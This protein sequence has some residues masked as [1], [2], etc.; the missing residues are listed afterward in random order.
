[1]VVDRDQ[2][3]LDRPVQDTEVNWEALW[4]AYTKHVAL[5]NRA[6]RLAELIAS[7]DANSDLAA[8]QLMHAAINLRVAATAA[9][10]GKFTWPPAPSEDELNN[11][12]WVERCVTRARAASEA[13]AENRRRNARLT[14]QLRAVGIGTTGKGVPVWQQKSKLSLDELADQFVATVAEHESVHGKFER[15]WLDPNNSH[16]IDGGMTNK[17]VI[18]L[19]SMIAGPAERPFEECFNIAMEYMR[20]RRNDAEQTGE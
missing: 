17:Q 12:A 3:T 4:Q 9:G 20:Q 11:S 5:E 15:E 6:G 16:F 10:L 13:A 18:I 1:M 7:L 14:R 8:P 19:A 2:S